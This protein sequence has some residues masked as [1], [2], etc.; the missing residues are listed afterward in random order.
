MSQ[1]LTFGFRNKVTR[2]PQ[3]VILED[4]SRRIAAMR[5]TATREAP[6]WDLRF[7]VDANELVTWLKSPAALPDLI[8]L[9]CDL[10]STESRG[11]ECGS[12][13]DVAEFLSSTRPQCPVIIHSTNALRAPAMHLNLALVGMS[14]VYLCPFR[15]PAEWAQ[16][17]RT[18]FADV[19]RGQR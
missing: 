4:D 11:I 13:E 19:S 6:D 7:F 9:D 14:H 8:S 16:D 3:V 2:M 5:S 15:D 12:G 10:D 17:L 18:A 1:I